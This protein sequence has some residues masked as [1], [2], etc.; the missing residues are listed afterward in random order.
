PT[1]TSTC[2]T[3][4][5]GTFRYF[6]LPPKSSLKNY[7]ILQTTMISILEKPSSSVYST[8]SSS[9]SSKCVTWNEKSSVLKKPLFASDQRKKPLFTFES[10]K[11]K[12]RRA[13]SETTTKRRRPA[14]P[15]PL[16]SILKPP[17]TR[18][19]GYQ[20]D[21]DFDCSDNTEDFAD[22]TA[23]LGPPELSSSTDLDDTPPS[24]ALPTPPDS[25][26]ASYQ[27]ESDS[28]YWSD[29]WDVTPKLPSG[30]NS[31][32]RSYEPQTPNALITPA[33][34]PTLTLVES[35]PTPGE[36]LEGLVASLQYTLI[37]C[38]A[39][40]LLLL[41]LACSALLF[42]TCGAL[43]ASITPVVFLAY[44]LMTL[45]SNTKYSAEAGFQSAI[46]IGGGLGLWIGFSVVIAV[47][48]IC[49]E[50]VAT[51]A[52]VIRALPL[53]IFLISLAALPAAFLETNTYDLLSTS[54]G[55][56]LSF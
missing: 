40:S 47:D 44:G 39:A 11:R 45:F 43:I 41:M 24:S 53:T 16:Q 18:S 19:P 28:D 10:F 12:I 33:S 6:Y 32:P 46:K 17:T 56:L 34:T 36:F 51:S 30:W 29:E 5:T 27:W 25:D 35:T 3:P 9:S 54:I 49:E 52:I 37:I 13:D 55:F 42:F 4:Q 8:T 21:L 1:H 15:A 38:G 31:P 22:S 26:T 23:D 20:L 2:T 7:Q 48:Y 50:I 14:P